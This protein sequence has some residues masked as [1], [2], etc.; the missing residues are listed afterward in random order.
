M[1][2]RSVRL[3]QQ[4]NRR[5]RNERA[6]IFDDKFA[7]CLAEVE[8]EDWEFAV[9]MVGGNPNDAARS[10]G[11]KGLP[12]SIRTLWGKSPGH[13]LETY[14]QWINRKKRK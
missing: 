2:T 7:S 11:L 4:D 13:A 1:G 8:R 9:E 5:S 10:L 14:R 6:F 12:K 3:R